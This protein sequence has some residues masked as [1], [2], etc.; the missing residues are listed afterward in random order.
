MF[1]DVITIGAGAAGFMA[2]I[3]AAKRKR[4]VLLIDHSPKIGEK[5][6]ISG[7]G[8]CNFT[9]INASPENYISSNPHFCKSALASYRPEDFIRLVKSHYIPFH[10]KKLGQLFCDHSSSAIIEMLYKEADKYGVE[11]LNPCRVDQINK[12]DKGFS[13]KTTHEDF[14]CESL[15]IATGG[16]SIPKIGATDFGYKI[17]KQFGLNIIKTRPG[18]VPLVF[19]DEFIKNQAG[20]SFDASV[21]FGKAKFRE[22]ILF[23]HN[24]LSGPAI[25]Q[26]SNYLQYGD[27]IKIDLCP[28]LNLKNL[29]L[30]AKQ[31]GEKK[32]LKNILKEIKFSKPQNEL[33]TKIQ[34][35]NIF[36]DKFIDSLA[37]AMDLEKSIAEVSNKVFDD[38][39]TNLQNWQLEP[40]GDEGYAKAEVTLG[41]VDTKEL[42]SKTMESKKIPG[43]YFI[44]EVVDV[45]GWLGGYNFQWAWAS[46]YAAGRAC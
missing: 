34:R 37:D 25:L 14:N 24:G 30:E 1:Y 5:I 11:I 40:S 3:E 39:V 18:L 16:L 31:S 23:T 28:D 45:T 7:G 19:E 10:E 4:K 12:N 43:L 27:A 26:I 41:G 13:L 29:L 42:D 9:N 2:A 17:A 22:N 38:L 46:G 8:R 32:K 20:T 21:S 35:E 15:I 36:P 33:K 6:R 44:G